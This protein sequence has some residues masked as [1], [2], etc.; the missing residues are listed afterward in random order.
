MPNITTNHAITY[1]NKNSI[2]NTPFV[3]F[4]F[5]DVDGLKWLI[6][7]ELMG[8]GSLSLSTKV[9]LIFLLFNRSFLFFGIF[10]IL[11]FLFSYFFLATLQHIAYIAW[12]TAVFVVVVAVFLFC[13]CLFVFF[14]LFQESEE[15]VERGKCPMG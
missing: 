15:G 11:T 12:R 6:G 5:T 10:S 8:K 14:R 1:T 3:L 9:L 7:I 2:Q 4:V 13:C